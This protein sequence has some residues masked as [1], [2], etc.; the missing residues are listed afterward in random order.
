MYKNLLF[1]LLISLLVFTG[2]NNNSNNNNEPELSGIYVLN[3]G[4]YG[5][6]N[7]SITSF[8]PLTGSV[9]QNV[10]EAANGRP[11][12][13]LL[14]SATLIDDKLYLV[15]NNSHKIEVVEPESFTE[16]A[17]INIAD[18]ASPRFIAKAGENKAYVTNLYGNS[19]SV[20]DLENMEETA[21]IDVGLNPEGIGIVGNRA[22]VANSAFGDG[23]TVSVID[24]ESD[25]VINTITVGD[26]PVGIHVDEAGRVWVTCVGAYNDFNDPDDDTPGELHIL[27]G[28]TGDPIEVITVGGHPGDFV[29]NYE[30]G[31]GYLSNGTVFE[32]NTTSYEIVNEQFLDTGFYALGL[33][34]QDG[35]ISLWGSDAGNFS[36][37]GMAY[38]FDASGAKVDSF[39]TGIIPGHFYFN[40]N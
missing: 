9:S 23:N 10:F 24:T 15:V 30:A 20:I 1:S 14:H 3:E 11:I 5:Q 35:E 17:T 22:Y 18:E 38:E 6:A 32:I 7:A 2:C 16:I 31:K 13:D 4:N 26:N 28:E 40:F 21:T 12:G 25:E 36:Q 8:N 29:M 34:E 37:D 39:S 19:V 27:D 33:F